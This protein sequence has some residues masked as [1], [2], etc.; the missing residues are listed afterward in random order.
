MGTLCMFDGH[1][2]LLFFSWIFCN[3]TL[4][5]VMMMTENISKWKLYIDIKQVFYIGCAHKA[6]ELHYVYW[7]S[8]SPPLEKSKIRRILDVLYVVILLSEG[9]FSLS[10]ISMY[11]LFFCW[12]VLKFVVAI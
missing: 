5:W 6:C 7:K 11:I 8:H 3:T 9:F 4:W 2:K 1:I 12:C 10:S